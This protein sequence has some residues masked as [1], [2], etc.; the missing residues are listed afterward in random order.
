MR[1]R[2]IMGNAVRLAIMSNTFRKYNKVGSVEITEYEDDKYTLV[3][4]SPDDFP[5]ILASVCSSKGRAAYNVKMGSDTI[6]VYSKWTMDN[7]RRAFDNA[8]GV[9]A[10]LGLRGGT[11]FS[12]T[13]KF[14]F[15]IAYGALKRLHNQLRGR[16][17]DSQREKMYKFESNVIGPYLRNVC[18]QN[19]AAYYLSSKQASAVVKKI[20]DFYGIADRVEVL[21]T[22][23]RSDNRLG[24]AFTVTSDP[25]DSEID[26]WRVE[27][28][29]NQTNTVTLNTVIHEM[30]HVVTGAEIGTKSA[31]HG[32]QFTA[33]YIELLARICSIEIKDLVDLFLEHNIK[34]DTKSIYI[35]EEK[36]FYRHTK[37]R[38]TRKKTT[39][40]TTVK[41]SRRSTRK[42]AGM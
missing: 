26:M 15:L 27:Y 17:R 41:R 33:V 16:V 29:L 7:L 23:T 40:K 30:A 34:V 8:D 9:V 1:I 37:E 19:K 11:C 35:D 39:P 10:I 6:G 38:M 12:F 21:F 42:A 20:T 36:K 32:D 4:L 24:R 25:L 3:L 28:H 5:Q 31:S 2:H 22:N 18:T 14:D 13:G